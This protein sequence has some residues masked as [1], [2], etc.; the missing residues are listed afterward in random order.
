MVR[1]YALPTKDENIMIC[2]FHFEQECFLKKITDTVLHFPVLI[3][4][5]SVEVSYKILALK[6][7]Y[8]FTT[9]HL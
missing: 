8:K 3:N 6:S 5:P 9:K 1:P 7:Y 4:Y 2:K